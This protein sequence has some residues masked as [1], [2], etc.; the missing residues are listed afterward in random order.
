MP[1]TIDEFRA[2]TPAK[3]KFLEIKGFRRIEALE[4]TTPTMATLVYCGTHVGFV[5]SLDVRDQCVDAE[6]V[7]VVNGQILRNWQGGYSS[8][9]FSHLV[10]HEGYRGRR[11]ALA[12]NDLGVS[13]TKIE[14][15]LNGWIALL[16]T[17]GEKLLSDREDSV[18]LETLKRPPIS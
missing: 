10:K 18:P 17:A 13:D 16:Q 11:V 12:T 8:S 3:M 2:I 4:E 6:V 14:R 7:K 9:L 5:F 1:I 15:E